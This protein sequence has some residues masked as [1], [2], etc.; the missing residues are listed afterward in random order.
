MRK[1]ADGQKIKGDAPDPSKMH[2]IILDVTNEDQ[3]QAAY[4]EVVA[5]T[6]KT[7]KPFAALVNNAGI[8]TAEPFEH[9]PWETFLKTINVNYIG[10]CVQCA[11]CVCV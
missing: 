3:I 1:D 11:V 8:L 4:K 2:P 6:K 10:R 5:W 9:V 7:G